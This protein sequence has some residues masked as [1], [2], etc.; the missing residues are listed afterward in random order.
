MAFFLGILRIPTIMNVSMLPSE[1]ARLVL[2]K[3][4]FL[5]FLVRIVFFHACNNIWF[6]ILT[7]FAVD[8]LA[9]EGKL[10]TYKVFLNESK[11]LREIKSLVDNGESVGKTVHGKTLKDLLG[12]S[13]TVS[14]AG[15]KSIGIQTASDVR[16][17]KV[18]E[19]CSDNEKCVA[20]CRPHSS[21]F[22]KQEP[23]VKNVK[24]KFYINASKHQSVRI[25]QVSGHGF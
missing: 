10:E 24:V 4:C 3:R 22:H 21:V 7:D 15:S 14:R 1:I 17:V 23:H 8:Y 9:E 19:Y 13:K 2:S 6:F 5:S 16:Y 11:Q 12:A 20:P 18:D 25:F